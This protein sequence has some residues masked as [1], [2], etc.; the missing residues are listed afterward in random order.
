MGGQER[1]RTL[2]PNRAQTK[3]EEL[4]GVKGR[5]QSGPEAKVNTVPKIEGQQEGGEKPREM[6]S[7]P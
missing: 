4:V 6:V 5:P 2:K 7:Q 3:A 1:A